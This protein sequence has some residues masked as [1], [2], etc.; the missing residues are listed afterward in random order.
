MAL[1]KPLGPDPKS[2][3][4]IVYTLRMPKL[5]ACHWLLSPAAPFGDETPE[6]F[7]ITPETW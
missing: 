7:Q 3:D 4:Y 6:G 1:V 2:L 5:L